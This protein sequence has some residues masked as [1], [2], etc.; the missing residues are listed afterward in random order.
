MNPE[1]RTQ[2]NSL[3][4]K[5][6]LFILPPRR[7]RDEE[8]LIPRAFFESEGAR[9]TVASSSTATARG[10]NGTTVVPDV[11]VEAVEAGGFDGVFL[12]GG[13]GSITFWHNATVHRIVRHA[14]DSGRVVGAICL[15]P[16]TLANAGILQ[17]RPATAYPSAEGSLAWKGAIYTGV[18]VQ[19]SGT[20]VTANG[21]EAAEE[22]ARA[23]AGLLAPESG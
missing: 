11:S 22:A 5:G 12:V 13:V 21:P 8:Y 1:N 3:L 4:G 16:V 7:F 6:I 9:V 10:M 19:V 20:I 18:P 2:G 15:A 23:V 14:Q 17:G